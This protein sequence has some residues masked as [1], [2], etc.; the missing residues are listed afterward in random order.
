MVEAAQ[1]KFLDEQPM[2]DA[3][4]QSTARLDAIQDDIMTKARGGGWGTTGFLGY[5]RQNASNALNTLNQVFNPGSAPPIDPT[6]EASGEDLIKE[7][8]G[9]IPK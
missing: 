6:K 2:Y 1:K 3:A 8:K 5:F 9:K 7:T 4:A